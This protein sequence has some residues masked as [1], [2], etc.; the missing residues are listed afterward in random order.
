MYSENVELLTVSPDVM[1]F[2]TK[3]QLIIQRKQMVH[4]LL[5]IE[6]YFNQCDGSWKSS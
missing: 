2:N 1:A 4:S 3:E 6:L 5:L